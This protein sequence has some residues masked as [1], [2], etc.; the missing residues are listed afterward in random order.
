MEADIY[1]LNFIA[2]TNFVKKYLRMM[3]TKSKKILIV[4][5][6]ES[7]YSIV[8]EGFD[9]HN[10]KDKFFHWSVSYYKS[11][12]FPIPYGHYK[13]KAKNLKEKHTNLNKMFS[14]KKNAALVI[15]SNCFYTNSIRLEYI[16]NLEKYF[17]IDK[18]GGCY[19]NKIGT[20]QRI[21]KL[22][23]YKFYLSFENTQCQEYITEKYWDT[24]QYGTIP[25]VMGYGKK[26]PDLIPDSYINVFD[27]P[28]PKSL[29]EYLIFLS[30]NE[31]AYSKYHEWRKYYSAHNYRANTCKFLSKITKL[32]QNPISE[33]LTVHLL[34]DK[35]ICL[36]LEDQKNLILKN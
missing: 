20:K 23:K 14:Q 32:M 5:S 10:S 22:S 8:R 1:F 36:S 7:P 30:I 15:I 9:Y 18:F 21:E 35:S 19:K 26:L 2:H 24:V 28:N 16:E 13:K 6:W 34:Q 29:S 27:F 25:I 3:Q 31:T 17:T 11:S 33:D 12:F 4:Y